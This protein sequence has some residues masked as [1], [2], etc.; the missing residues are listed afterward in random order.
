MNSPTKIRSK[1]SLSSSETIHVIPAKTG[2]QLA[3]SDST[4]TLDS[5]FRGNDSGGRDDLNCYIKSTSK[6]HMGFTLVELLVVISLISLL[7]ALLL[8]AL[9]SA[10]NTSKKIVCMNNLEQ[11]GHLTL[12][13]DDDNNGYAPW[14]AT[15][16]PNWMF[17]GT[18]SNPFFAKYF[19][20]VKYPPISIC[21][22]GGRD[23][24]TSLTT[25]DN[26]NPNFSY[27]LSQFLA[28]PQNGAESIAPIT[29][30]TQPSDTALWF[31]TDYSV[32]SY[33]PLDVSGRHGS[34]GTTVSHSTYPQFLGMANV[35]YADGG[36]RS[37]LVPSQVPA[38]NTSPFWRQ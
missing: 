12:I 14:N 20:N 21:P 23:G 1:T 7:M 11:L 25:Y 35:C 29:S 4:Q 5:R 18:S 13:Y 27:G 19:T 8:P 22:M 26:G 30:L 31:E 17:D 38:Y 32:A 33:H 28:N 24:T 10:K 3:P 34:A 6:N 9:K 16:T 37:I 2:I 15:I 36:V